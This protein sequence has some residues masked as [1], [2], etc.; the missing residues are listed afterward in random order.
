MYYKTI[1]KNKS[2][3]H[4]ETPNSGIHNDTSKLHSHALVA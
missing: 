2:K 3:S 4:L 1:K